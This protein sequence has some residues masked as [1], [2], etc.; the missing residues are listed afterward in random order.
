MDEAMRA[1]TFGL[2]GTVAALAGIEPQLVSAT[3]QQ[4]PNLQ[5]GDGAPDLGAKIS[6]WTGRQVVRARGFKNVRPVRCIGDVYRYEGWRWG[7]VW[8]IRISAFTGK[9]LS[10]RRLE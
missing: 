7:G 6:C 1:R 9:F 8:R 10:A 3:A 5:L 2:I 4:T